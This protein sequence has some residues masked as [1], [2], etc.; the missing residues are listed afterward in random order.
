MNVPIRA[1]VDR[2][3]DD[4][5]GG[6][7]YDRLACGHIRATPFNRQTL[8][9]QHLESRPCPV[10]LFWRLVLPWRWPALM[11]RTPPSS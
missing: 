11:A 6:K 9:F 5:H 3:V 8:T 10:C 2:V 4:Y 1:V 7:E